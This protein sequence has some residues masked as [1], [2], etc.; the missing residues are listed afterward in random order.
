M[1]EY[2]R[3]GEYTY[4]NTI[5]YRWP[6]A[7]RAAPPVVRP[8]VEQVIDFMRFIGDNDLWDRARERFDR[9]GVTEIV[10]GWREVDLFR[11][12]ITDV[13]TEQKPH[14]ELTG[15]ASVA[16]R[17]GCPPPQTPQVPHHPPPPWEDPGHFL[18]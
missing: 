5:E 15:V 6:A 11:Q 10:M 16:G 4:R 8:S 9:E 7:G 18:Q 2:D 14:E 17:C 13:I 1:A 3:H 12:F